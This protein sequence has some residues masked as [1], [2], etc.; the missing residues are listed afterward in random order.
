M[1]YIKDIIRAFIRKNA[2]NNQTWLMYLDQF[3][4]GGHRDVPNIDDDPKIVKENPYVTMLYLYDKSNVFKERIDTHYDNWLRMNDLADIENKEDF[5]HNPDNINLSDQDLHNNFKLN[6]MAE[7]KD[8]NEIS[9]YWIKKRGFTPENAVRLAGLEPLSFITNK[10]LKANIKYK[11]DTNDADRKLSIAIDYSSF[12]GVN[13]ILERTI[14]VPLKKEPYVEANLL[15]LS[16]NTHKNQTGSKILATMIHN[17]KKLGIE[18]ITTN[19]AKSPA[20][21]RNPMI[22]YYV[23]PKMGYDGNLTSEGDAK[24]IKFMVN[25]RAKNSDIYEKYTNSEVNPEFGTQYTIQN[26]YALGPEAVELWKKYGYE[27][28][29]E[30]NLDD[31]SISMKIWNARM[32]KIL[33]KHNGDMKQWLYGGSSQ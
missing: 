8:F 15:S 14:K 24:F 2:R 26:L 30:F 16:E 7:Q 33:A 6:V 25:L 11:I 13:I 20:T 17:A 1:K 4:G 31:N 10:N 32:A 27:L 29:G 19:M 9:E 18:K 21:D 5:A 28:Y 23:W 12:K 22:G 3:W